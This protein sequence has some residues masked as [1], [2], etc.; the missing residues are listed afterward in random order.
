MVPVHLPV[1]SMA[2]ITD[3]VRRTGRAHDR[4]RQNHHS[5]PPAP[6]L[7]RR[8]LPTPSTRDQVAPTDLLTTH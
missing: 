3:L 7:Q 1:T 5:A 6:L 4:Y 2:D 8:D